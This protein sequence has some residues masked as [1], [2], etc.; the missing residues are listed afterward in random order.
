MRKIIFE[1]VEVSNGEDIISHAYD[2]LM[3]ALI[4][5]SQE[6]LLQ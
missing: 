4:V 1:I 3:M 6:E 5:L 2:I